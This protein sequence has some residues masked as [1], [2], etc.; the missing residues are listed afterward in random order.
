MLSYARPPS[1]SVDYVFY[2]IIGVH[3][4]SRLMCHLGHKCYRQVESREKQFAQGYFRT[5]P[6]QREWWSPR[7]R[8]WIVRS[9]LWSSA[10][11]ELAQ[12]RWRLL[13]N[14]N[15]DTAPFYLQ[16][17][18]NAALI[19]LVFLD[20]ANNQIRIE[21]HFAVCRDTSTLRHNDHHS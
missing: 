8:F 7:I 20:D 16:T 13:S 5:Y 18:N 6:T 11:I 2:V 15:L 10:S 19:L 9:V 17:A 14:E 21:K 3:K 12:Y 4:M 1:P